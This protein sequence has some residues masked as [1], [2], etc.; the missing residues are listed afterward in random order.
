[1]R[2]AILAAL[3]ATSFLA[4]T[5]AAYAQGAGMNLMAADANK[6]G[7]VTQAEMK[8]AREA[9]FATVDAN[10]NGFAEASEM[11]PGAMM[12]Q[13]SD[14]NGD[15]KLDKAEFS[16]TSMMFGFLDANKDGAIDSAELANMP[17]RPGG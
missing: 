11:G 4:L 7:K 14:K 5:G 16:D 3:A 15:G 17:A 9:R 13:R 8:A 1:M 12:I 10:K 2:K 6:D